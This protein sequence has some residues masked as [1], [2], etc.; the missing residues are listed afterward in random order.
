MYHSTMRYTQ[1]QEFA[2]GSIDVP[3]IPLGRGFVTRGLE[4]YESSEHPMHPWVIART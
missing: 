3:S 2:K 4:S 1:L